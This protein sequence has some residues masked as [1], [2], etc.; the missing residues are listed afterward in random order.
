MAKTIAPGRSL[1]EHTPI[2]NITEIPLTMHGAHVSTFFL[3]QV[4]AKK[5]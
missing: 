3:W 4:K 2:E 1:P 5:L